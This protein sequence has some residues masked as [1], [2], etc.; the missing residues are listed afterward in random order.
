MVVEDVEVQRQMLSEY[1]KRS[2]FDVDEAGDGAQLRALCAANRY[3]LAV[4]DLHLPDEDGL[5]LVRF[6]RSTQDAG[7]I[8][9]TG[10]DDP[11]DRI[12]GLE[13]GADDYLVKPHPPRELLARARG[14][15]RRCGTSAAAPAPAAKTV[16]ALGDW[17]LSDESRSLVSGSGVRVDLTPSEFVLMREFLAAPGKILDREHL[18]R[19][20]F[21]RAWEYEDRAM[22]VL[23]T[24]LR[25]KIE[26]TRE[27]HRIKSVRGQGYMLEA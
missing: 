20:V 14:V 4:V 15:L 10:N 2:G 16:V 12:V 17:T 22:D 7:I 21:N 23:V 8:V 26:P 18:M 13:I 6:L 11:T 24:R 9:L 5:D 27:G 3:D 19:S 25:Q 1:L